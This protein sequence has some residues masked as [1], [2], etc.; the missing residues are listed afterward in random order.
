MTAATP[1][2]MPSAVRSERT[3]L[4]RMLGGAMQR[5]ALSIMAVPRLVASRD[6]AAVTECRRARLAWAAMSEFVRDH[7]DRDAALAVELREQ[8]A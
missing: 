7:H 6:H 1:M 2:T 3:A 4:R 5:T 8:A